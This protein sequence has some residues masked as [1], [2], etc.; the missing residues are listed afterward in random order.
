MTRLIF[1]IIFFL[2]SLLAIFKA[3]AYYLWLLAVAVTEYPLIFVAIS[4][5]LTGWGYWLN[6]Y[7][8]A[9]TVIR[10]N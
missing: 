2:I 1:I 9:G 4:G 8:T 7:Q 3:P 10:C 5:A 6:K